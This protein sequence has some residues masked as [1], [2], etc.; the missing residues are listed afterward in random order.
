M[1][2][3]QRHGVSIAV[4]F[5]NDGDFSPFRRIMD[6][7]NN[8]KDPQRRRAG[9]A[10]L[11]ACLITLAR[12]LA[13]TRR[14]GVRFT[15]SPLT[16]ENDLIYAMESGRDIGPLGTQL[17]SAC[18]AVRRARPDLCASLSREDAPKPVAPMPVEVVAMP[19]RKTVTSVDRNMA[20]EITSAMQLESD[21]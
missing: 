3:I 16:T 17:V 4:Q 19:S 11:N 18:N 2:Q 7:A 5:F 15:G 13:D 8:A 1:N 12:M 6:D 21:C 9:H 20:G 10:A 14:Y